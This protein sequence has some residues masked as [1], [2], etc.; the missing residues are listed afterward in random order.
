MKFRFLRP[1]L[2]LALALGL[3]AC[4]GKATFDINVEISG[5]EYN[6]LTLTD[7]KSNIKL[8]LPAG[9]TKIKFP[10]T[11]EYGDEY[12]IVIESGDMPE[13]QTCVW[14]GGKDTAGRLSEI[15]VGVSCSVLRPS[16]LGTITVTAATGATAGVPT[17]LILRFGSDF[18]EFKAADTSTAYGFPGIPY[19]TDFG[20]VIAKQPDSAKTTCK[21][22]LPATD[23]APGTMGPGNLSF[24]GTMGD[25]NVI[26]NVA[27]TTVP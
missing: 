3:S 17:G 4:G 22:A 13:H 8:D 24:T 25:V 18:P 2:L 27:C 5:L 20:L 14:G 10:R 1:S 23:P 9:T 21:L 6:G 12:E 11:L 7:R 19:S 16:V 26:V 15:T